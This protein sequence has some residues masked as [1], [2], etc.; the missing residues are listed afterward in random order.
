MK[1]FAPLILLLLCATE[2]ALAADPLLTRVMPRGGTRGTELELTFLGQRLDDAKE[3]LFYEPGI[4]VK[5]VKS[6]GANSCKAKVAIA[7]DARIGEYRFRIRTESG[8]SPLRTFFVG[9]LRAVDEKEPNNDAAKPQRLDLNVTVAGVMESE[10]ADC[11]AVEA[12]KG[13]RISAEVEGMRLGTAMFDPL[14]T[15]LDDAGAEIATCDDSAL[16]LQD[17]FVSF[18]APKDGRYVIKLR[19]SSYGG[20]GDTY[21]R[22]HVGTFP[23]P[24]AVYPA[25]GEVGHE[26]S[27]KFLG[28]PTGQFT[29]TIKLGAEADQHFRLFPEQD[30]RAAPSG[31]VFRVS[32]FPN[33]LEAEP[34]E[35]FDKATSSSGVNVPLAI[36]G[37]IEKPGDVDVFRFKATKGQALEIR[38]YARRLRSPLDPVIRVLNPKG[39][40]ISTNDDSGGPDSY[41]RLA[42]PEDGEYGVAVNDQLR[43]GG[44][45][46]V[47]R[48]E[49]TPAVPRVTLALP[50]FDQFNTSQER[51]TIVVPKGNRFATLVR[52]TRSDFGGALNLEANGLPTGVT[53]TTDGIGDGGDITPVVFEASPDAKPTGQLVELVAKPTKSEAKLESAFRQEI[54]LVPNGNQRPFYTTHVD[55]LAVAVA[56]EAPFKLTLVQPKVPLVQ[57]GSMDLRLHVDRKPGFDAPI[58]LRMVF[59]PPGVTASTNSEIDGGKSD[60]FIPL[61]A[62]DG[63]PAKQWKICVLGSA[64]TD[65][66]RVWT[67]T[68][69]GALD[70]AAPMLAMSMNLASVERGKSAKVVVNIEDKTPFDGKAKVR[71]VGLPPNVKAEP[72]ELEFTAKD[73]TVTF[74]VTAKDRAPVGT[75]RSLLCVATITKDGE[76]IVHNLARGGALRVDEPAAAKGKPA[77]KNEK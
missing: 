50:F 6:N 19:E 56:E 8:V 76:P 47:Y 34:N 63:A 77:A 49:I 13:Q 37:I 48:V 51:Q 66:G 55:R 20:S 36:N 3:I 7:P 43:S 2:P 45:D 72:E 26:L 62:A 59:D 75:H 57:G 67:S 69:L 30:G 68:Q 27:V 53:M 4:T 41:L 16:F 21:Y 70:V 61:N 15:V 54:V 10:G 25:G 35:T 18:I 64:D 60:G 5:E 22:L 31:N 46:Y 24:T 23:R 44:P 29:Q 52:G 73:K 33:V 39:N 38:C 14:L 32:A 65:D 1:Y 28:D 71:L 12:N 11:F 58:R 40:A 74:S 42:V 9:N 17:P